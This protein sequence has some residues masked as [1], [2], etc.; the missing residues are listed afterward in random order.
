[1]RMH[2]QIDRPFGEAGR[3][4]VLDDEDSQ[5]DTQAFALFND[6]IHIGFKLGK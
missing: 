2:N 4:D 5:V 1:M 6:L 3:L